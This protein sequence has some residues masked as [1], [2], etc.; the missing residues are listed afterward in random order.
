MCPYKTCIKL[1]SVG[2]LAHCGTNSEDAVAID[3]IR[4]FQKTAST[5]DR[6]TSTP[7]TDRTTS[8]PTTDTTT[9]TPTT[10][11]TTLTT[12]IGTMPQPNPGNKTN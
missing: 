3:N 2:V 9:S 12:E 1:H 5:T 6:T 4:S 10:A 8:A 11:G 7:S